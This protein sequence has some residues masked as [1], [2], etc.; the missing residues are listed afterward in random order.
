[1]RK[2]DGRWRPFP[3]LAEKTKERERQREGGRRERERSSRRCCYFLVD[4]SIM[5][6]EHA[7]VEEEEAAAAG[8]GGA[9]EK[10]KSWGGEALATAQICVSVSGLASPDDAGGHRCPSDCSHLPSCDSHHRCA[11]GSPASSGWN[12]S[13]DS[14]R[15]HTWKHTH[16]GRCRYISSGKFIPV[17]LA[18]FRFGI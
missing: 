14:F 13:M 7:A 2:G 6:C 4:Q 16:V 17:Q 11:F 18:S 12:G 8:G 3:L 15:Q 10:A 9:V 1:M 5:V